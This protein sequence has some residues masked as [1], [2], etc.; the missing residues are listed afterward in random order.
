MAYDAPLARALDR[1]GGVAML[2]RQ[3]EISPSAISQWTRVPA[4]WLP[5]IAIITQIPAYELRPD[6]HGPVRKV[7]PQPT[8][9][10]P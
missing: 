3:L 5:R 10:R 4:H 9:A 8:A 6:L 7:S 2:A 1:V